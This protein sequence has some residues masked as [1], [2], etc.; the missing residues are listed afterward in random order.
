VDKAGNVRDYE[1]LRID[2]RGA[3]DRDAGLN[4]RGDGPKPQKKGD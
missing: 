1:V 3:G 4:A 2:G